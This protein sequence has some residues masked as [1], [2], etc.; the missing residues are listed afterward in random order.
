MHIRRIIDGLTYD[1][2]RATKIIEVPL[3][4]VKL[5]ADG[6][7][8]RSPETEIADAGMSALFQMQKGGFF[9]VRRVNPGAMPTRSRALVAVR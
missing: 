6:R 3:R 1:P 8:I 4:G 5:A 9:I 7:I 2:D